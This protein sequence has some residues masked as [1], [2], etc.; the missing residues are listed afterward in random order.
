[1]DVSH[2][3]CL[4]KRGKKNPGAQF[5]GIS[6]FSAG[7]LDKSCRLQLED[8]LVDC[9]WTNS[10]WTN[11]LAAVVD[12]VDPSDTL[13]GALYM[14]LPGAATSLFTMIACI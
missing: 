12:E 5:M 13:W 2:K 1:M 3:A 11:C 4:S 10:R 9:R 7:T 14:P 6:P 8:L